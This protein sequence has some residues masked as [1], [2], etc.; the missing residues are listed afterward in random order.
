VV[1]TERRQDSGPVK[2][3]RV[4]PAKRDVPR[5]SYARYGHRKDMWFNVKTEL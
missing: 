4:K 1:Y 5:L 3:A 2:S